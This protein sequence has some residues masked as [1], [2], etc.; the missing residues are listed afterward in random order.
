MRGEPKCLWQ[1]QA[2]FMSILLACNYL[3]K[4]LIHK[5]LKGTFDQQM[6]FLRPTI[7]LL[8]NHQLAFKCFYISIY[9]YRERSKSD[10]N[11]N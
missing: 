4:L 7:D 2:T 6:V 5:S 11:K 9:L 3:E 8:I 10:V 1:M